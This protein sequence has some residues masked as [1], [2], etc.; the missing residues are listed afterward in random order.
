[1]ITA[2]PGPHRL[3][4]YRWREA[5]APSDPW[6]LC[7]HGFTGDGLDFAPYVEASEATIGEVW[8]VDLLGHG[9]SDAPRAPRRYAERAAVAHLEAII[10]A[11]QPARSAP[12]RL[13]GYSMGGRLALQWAA[14]T[15]RRPAAAAAALILI[16]A[17]PGI[18][19]AAERE[20]R[21]RSDAALIELLERDGVEAF[22][23]FWQDVPL[24]RSQR[25]IKPEALAAMRARRATR[26]AAGLC[27]SLEGF[28]AGAMSS[29]W[30]KLP[31]IHTP[32]LSLSGELDTKYSALGQRLEAIMPRARHAVIAGAGHAPHLERPEATAEIVEAFLGALPAR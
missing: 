17:S 21:R 26:R 10:R 13:L 25:Q 19:T 15:S 3:I 22:M 28:G 31:S 1:M 2:R 23:R 11:I 8:S 7:L 27:G 18:K 16:G 12:L 32:T 30:P 29:L 6:T 9:L 5:R 24:L 4:A 14:S 20:Q